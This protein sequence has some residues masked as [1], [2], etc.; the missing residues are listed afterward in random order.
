MKLFMTGLLI[1]YSFH[2]YS[3]EGK[4]LQDSLNE[5]DSSNRF[6]AILKSDDFFNKHLTDTVRSIFDQVNILDEVFI[7]SNSEFN[8]VSLGILKKEIKPLTPYERQLYTA[9]DFKPV[10]LLSILTGSLNVDPIINAITGRTKRLKKYIQ[11]E[12]KERNLMFLEDHFMVYLDEN[13]EIKEEL[14]GRFLGYLVEN[15]KLQPL[16]DSEDL[17]ALHFFIGDEWFYFKK[18][19]E[20]P[21]SVLR[22]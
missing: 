12:K 4:A 2:S 19:Q 5:K 22:D 20:E 6:Q 16:I 3:Q 18:L 11:I 14:I 17:G 15:E 9:G 13:L 10:H 7:A 1:L 21:A 8:A